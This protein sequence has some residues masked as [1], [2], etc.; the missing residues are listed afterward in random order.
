MQHKYRKLLHDENRPIREIKVSQWLGRI[1][2]FLIT[3]ILQEFFLEVLGKKE[4]ME[5]KKER[6]KERRK[7]NLVTG[8]TGTYTTCS[9]PHTVSKG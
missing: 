5:E 6:R 2:M 4:K 9:K 3:E 7:G 1:A 8:N